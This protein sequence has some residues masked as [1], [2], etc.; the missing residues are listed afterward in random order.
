MR[1]EIDLAPLAE[2][3][4]WTDGKGQDPHLSWYGFSDARY[5]IQV[6]SEYLLSYSDEKVANSAKRYPGDYVGPCVSYIGARFWEDVLD[7]IPDV[8]RPVPT[9]LSE[10]LEQGYC[11]INA[12]G[13]RFY[14]WNATDELPDARTM[15]IL[16]AATAWVQDR[17]LDN[18]YLSRCSNIWMWSTEETVCIAWDNRGVQIDGLT[19]WS[20]KQGIYRQSR[21]KFMAA[22]RSFNDRFIAQMA[23]RVAEITT[24]WDRPEV[25]VGLEG[26]KEEQVLRAEYFDQVLDREP[27]F[28]RS[29]DEVTEAIRT[30][31]SV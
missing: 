6:G 20:A 4:P 3:Q 30:V 22:V 15:D 17:L 27:N 18:G 24:S 9:A 11:D 8:L 16:D 12:L 19:A 7:M 21:D 28:T 5:R 2:I 23:A 14:D 25:R 26:L 10:L 31:R 29:W 13:D 1:F